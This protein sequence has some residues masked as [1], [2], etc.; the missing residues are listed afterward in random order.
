M[1]PV[2]V[3]V[4]VCMPLF[5]FGQITL[6]QPQSQI[7]TITD[8]SGS[9]IGTQSS[10]ITSLDPIHTIIQLVNWFSWFVALIAVVMGLYAGFLFITAQGEP[11]KIATAQK[12]ILWAIL[13]IP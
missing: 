3:A 5:V 7:G 8:I 2:L 1:F 4:T 11:A 6:T 12:T 10:V 13:V 9:T